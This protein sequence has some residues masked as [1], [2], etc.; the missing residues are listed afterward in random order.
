MGITLIEL[1]PR[2][3]VAV[4]AET[5]V[6]LNIEHRNVKMRCHDFNIRVWSLYSIELGSLFTFHVQHLSAKSVIGAGLCTCFCPLN[7]LTW[8]EPFPKCDFVSAPNSFNS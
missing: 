7:Y 5:R 2:R 4:I 1:L 6:I 3:C 8:L